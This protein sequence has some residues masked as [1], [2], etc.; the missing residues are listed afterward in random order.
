MPVPLIALADHLTGGHVQ[1][2]KQRCGA[3]ADVVMGPSLGLPGLHGQERL[4]AVQGLHLALL[5][6]A[7][8]D[9][10]FRRS[11]V[12][13]DHVADHLHEERIT[14][15]LEGLATVRLEPEGTPDAADC[16]LRQ[17]E[18]GG[19][20][21]STPVSGRLGLG[22]QGLGDNLLD[23]GVGE[24]AWG[25]GTWFVGQTLQTPLDEPLPPGAD[26]G[27]ADTESG[28]DLRVI[29]SG[30]TRRPLPLEL[31]W[32][33]ELRRGGVDN[34]APMGQNIGCNTPM[35]LPQETSP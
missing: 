7:Q 21:T 3:V 33:M 10:V 8:D 9:G 2:R 34:E 30:V 24:L 4:G 12:Q 17:S 27:G 16:R 13:S 32:D 28:S 23:V 15:E 11:H 1:G 35:P 19:H 14:G 6:D 25:S 26:R 20:A 22:L 29:Q 31:F 5:I 18:F